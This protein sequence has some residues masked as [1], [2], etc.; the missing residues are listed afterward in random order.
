VGATYD[1]VWTITH[2]AKFYYPDVLTCTPCDANNHI[3]NTLFIKVLFTLF[4][5]SLF[6]ARLPNVLAF[7]MYSSYCAKIINLILPPPI[8]ARFYT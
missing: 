5:E 6:L 4:G 7:L 2:F 1:E 8:K 3:L